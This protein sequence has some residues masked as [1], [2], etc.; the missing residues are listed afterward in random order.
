[1]RASD[2]QLTGSIPEIYDGTPLRNEIASRDPSHAS[3]VVDQAERDLRAA[4]FNTR[5]GP[6]S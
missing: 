4:F 6:G 5:R 2:V 1:M 3:Q